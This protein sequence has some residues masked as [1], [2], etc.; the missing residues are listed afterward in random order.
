M[1]L[2]DLDER[3]RGGEEASEIGFAF[4]R[5]GGGGGDASQAGHAG[6]W[7]VGPGA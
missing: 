2:N 1:I 3:T 6:T 5:V 4:V 7:P